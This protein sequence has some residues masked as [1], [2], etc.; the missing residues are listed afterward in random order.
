MSV[1]I[2]VLGV[3]LAGN[4]AAP[5]LEASED[6]Q[7]QVLGA[8]THDWGE[9]DIRGGNVEKV[10]EIENTGDGDLEVTNFKTSC[11]CTEAQVV[12]NDEKSPVFGMHSRSSWKGVVSSGESAD[13]KVVFDPLFHGPQGTG[14]ITRLVSFETND[15]ESP[16]MEFKLTG[17]VVNVEN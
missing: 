11:M 9:I 10:F 12:I 8:M 4:S 3:V 13:V 1:G 15:P 2:L 17:N 5:E 14:P 6:A 16:R 7:M